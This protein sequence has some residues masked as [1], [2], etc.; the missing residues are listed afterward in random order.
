MIYG[1][2]LVVTQKKKKNR[3]LALLLE[4]ESIKCIIYVVSDYV[5][6]GGMATLNYVNDGLLKW[7]C[8]LRTNVTY[9]C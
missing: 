2:P 6:D 9:K 7:T 4:R 8:A 1:R 5:S 3:M